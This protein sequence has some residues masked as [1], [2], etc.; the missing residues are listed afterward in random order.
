MEQTGNQRRTVLQFTIQSIVLP[1]SIQS[2]IFVSWRLGDQGGATKPHSFHESSVDYNE[3]FDI[4]YFPKSNRN[5]FLSVCAKSQFG[6]IHSFGSLTI[7]LPEDSE[8]IKNLHNSYICKSSV[9]DFILCLSFVLVDDS[10]SFT[11][12]NISGYNEYVNLY[13]NQIRSMNDN[14]TI[15]IWHSDGVL[16]KLDNIISGTLS[17][18]II[19]E[20]ESLTPIMDEI[21]KNSRIMADMMAR[22]PFLFFD[23]EA[24]YVNTSGEIIPLDHSFNDNDSLIPL[25]AYYICSLCLRDKKFLKNN[26]GGGVLRSIT[27]YVCVYTSTQNDKEKNMFYLLSSCTYII[28]FLLSFDEKEFRNELNLLNVTIDSTLNCL[29][30][31]LM[32][33]I[34]NTNKSTKFIFNKIDEIFK[35][36]KY[37]RINDAISNQIRVFCCQSIDYYFIRNW[38]FDQEY[39]AIDYSAI[40]NISIYN[41]PIISSHELIIKFSDTIVKRKS[42]YDQIP[43]FM[44]GDWM[45]KILEKMVAFKI[46]K[47]KESDIANCVLDNSIPTLISIDEFSCSCSKIKKNH[48]FNPELPPLKDPSTLFQF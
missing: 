27:E 48:M 28:C 22:I 14:P 31:I 33:P 24:R 12:N 1:K 36:C 21:L 10:C 35:K 44:R 5:M 4:G 46:K 8:D 19:H 34:I 2:S 17:Q 41:W 13:A 16:M 38:I 42:P 26:N 3:V 15:S 11:C 18:E 37:Y 39:K 45:R 30:K 32:K 47:Y 20:L 23:Q 6:A 7:E 40:K 25:S 9:G 29:L 43:D